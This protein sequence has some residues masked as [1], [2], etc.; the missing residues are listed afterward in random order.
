MSYSLSTASVG[1]GPAAVAAL[2]AT[3]GVANTARSCDTFQAKPSQGSAAC[4]GTLANAPA[5]ALTPTASTQPTRT[6]PDRVSPAMSIS[7]YPDAIVTQWNQF[8]REGSVTFKHDPGGTVWRRIQPI[9]R[10]GRR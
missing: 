4:T 2:T 9:F 1:P 3:T 8:T 6:R 5:T 7:Y 10:H